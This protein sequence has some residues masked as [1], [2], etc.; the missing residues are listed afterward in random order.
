[1]EIALQYE[2]DPTRNFFDVA[3]EDYCD[4]DSQFIFPLSDWDLTC[5]LLGALQVARDKKV[6]LFPESL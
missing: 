6:D 4:V 2:G 5:Y 3:W 1:M